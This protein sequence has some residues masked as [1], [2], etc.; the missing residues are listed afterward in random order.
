MAVKITVQNLNR[1]RAA[2]KQAPETVRAEARKFII[3]AMSTLRSIVWNDPWRVG[4]TGGG[5]PVLTGNLRA[6]HRTELD[7]FTGVM[8]PDQTV[9]P[10]ARAVHEGHGNVEARPWLDYAE[11][12]GQKEV[13]EQAAQMVQDIAAAIAAA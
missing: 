4:N 2:F 11:R 12:T 6:S 10:Y 1:I 9:A 7:D 8:F 5:V 3:R 13:N